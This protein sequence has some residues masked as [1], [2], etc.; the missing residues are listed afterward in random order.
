MTSNLGGGGSKIL[1]L[2]VYGSAYNQGKQKTII[3]TA[4]V[5]YDMCTFFGALKDRCVKSRSLRSAIN[6]SYFKDNKTY[7]VPCSS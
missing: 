3:L 5:V 7:R 4:T 2:C 6:S 1:E